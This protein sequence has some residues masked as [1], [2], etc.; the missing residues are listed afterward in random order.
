MPFLKLALLQMSA[1][2]GN[3]EANTKIADQFCRKAAA[4]QSDIA[5]FPEMFSIGYPTPYNK[6]N[7]FEIWKKVAFQGKKPD[8][9]DEDIAKYRSYAIDDNHDYINHFHALAKELEMA[10]V[11]TYISK[12]KLYPRNTAL[13]IDRYGKD[14]LKY[15]KINLFQPFFIDAI[16]E[17]G[18]EFPVIT[19]DTKV[20]AVQLGILICAD[21][22]IPEP[23][24]ILMKQGAELVIIPNSCPL[25]GLNGM[26]LDATKMR[27]YENAMAV[28]ICNYPS[29]KN[30]EY[31]D[32]HSTAF[33]PDGS[34]LFEAPEEE[35]VYIVEYDLDFIRNYRAT[36]DFGDAFRSE[37]YFS[38]ILGGAVR[39]PFAGRKNAIGER[40]ESYDRR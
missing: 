31:N 22:N 13:V 10:I 32:G 19:I 17:S 18:E 27:A 4:K 3:I 37:V 28:T 23:A 26:L 24:R 21:R 14:V 6:N 33:N 8:H 38:G 25:K 36:T 2:E 1:V 15:S 30:D 40:P 29:S 9:F 20:G 34:C 7:S 11:V 35:D 39:S 12:G 16:C 5:V